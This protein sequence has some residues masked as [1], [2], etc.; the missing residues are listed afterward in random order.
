[1]VP[2]ATMS[3]NTPRASKS[4]RISVMVSTPFSS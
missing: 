3:P 1:M 4:E 2:V